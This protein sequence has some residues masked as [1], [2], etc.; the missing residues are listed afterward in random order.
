MPR[1]KRQCACACVIQLPLNKNM[2]LDLEDY[3][4]SFHWAAANA[5][6]SHSNFVSDCCAIF[7]WYFF[8]S[9]SSFTFTLSLSFSVPILYLSIYLRYIYCRV[10]SRSLC[11]W[12]QSEPSH[13]IRLYR[14]LSGFWLTLLYR[15]QPTECSRS[16]DLPKLIL[17]GD[18]LQSLFFLFFSSLIWFRFFFFHSLLFC[19]Y[20]CCII[21]NNLLWI[22]II[23][24]GILFWLYHIHRHK[25]HGNIRYIRFAM[26]ALCRLWYLSVDPMDSIDVA[27]RIPTM[28]LTCNLNTSMRCRT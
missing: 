16:S 20:V 25:Q 2:F 18:G 14:Y 1:A 21:C 4:G 17:V 23:R 15:V 12:L 5:Y 22:V 9:S 19:V 7:V 28:W 26:F 11:N 10:G 8:Y 13:R 24:A 3:F 6:I 27:P